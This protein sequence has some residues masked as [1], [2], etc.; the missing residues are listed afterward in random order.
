MADAP[1]Q[2]ELP[3]LRRVAAEA[4]EVNDDVVLQAGR[5]LPLVEHLNDR[6]VPAAAQLPRERLA[7]VHVSPLGR[8]VSVRG[9]GLDAE[10]QPLLGLLERC[11]ELPRP[12]VVGVAL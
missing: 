2:I 11:D 9:T 12:V 3:R 6:A 1:E 10:R 8:D 7:E 4:L 5:I